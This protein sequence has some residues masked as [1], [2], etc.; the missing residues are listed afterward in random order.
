MTENEINM[1]ATDA[2]IAKH[3]KLPTN[4]A[5][6]AVAGPPSSR[7]VLKVDAILAAHL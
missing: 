1:P 3:P 4:H 6:T 7:G 2:A 5:Q